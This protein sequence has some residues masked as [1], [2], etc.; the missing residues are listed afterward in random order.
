M[1]TIKIHDRFFEPYITEE[2]IANRIEE[3]ALSIKETYGN[4]L[5]VFISVLNGSFVFT[6]DLLRR[7]PEGCEVVFIKISSYAGTQSSGT[8]QTQMG[9]PEHIRNRDILILEDII[10]SG[11]SM[12]HLLEHAQSFAPASIKVATLLFKPTALQHPIT[13]DFTGFEIENKFVLGYGLDYNQLGRNLPCIYAE[14]E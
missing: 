8:V 3:L 4:Q 5:P 6:A 12:K 11:L 7:F 13:P 14:V 10:D 9:F 1:S 2:Q